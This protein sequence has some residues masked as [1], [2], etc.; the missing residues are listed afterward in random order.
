MAVVNKQL[1]T[2]G[3]WDGATTTNTLLSLSSEM[4]W[5][6]LLPVMLTRRVKPAA[7]A[8]DGHL[9]VAAGWSWTGLWTVEVLIPYS[10]PM[11]KVYLEQCNI[12]I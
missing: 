6:R 5:E 2:I 11:Q 1:T 4:K 10:G 8:T 9:V 7:V 12:H 3:G